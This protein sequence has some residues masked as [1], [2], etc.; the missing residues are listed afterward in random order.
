[1]DLPPQR[2]LGRTLFMLN[3]RIRA[4]SFSK[5]LIEFLLKKFHLLTIFQLL[6]I[7]AQY[8]DFCFCF[9]GIKQCLSKYFSSYLRIVSFFPL[10]KIARQLRNWVFEMFLLSF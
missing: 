9:F 5:P 4:I 2:R 7:F 1:M 8:C 6:C 10:S 3:T